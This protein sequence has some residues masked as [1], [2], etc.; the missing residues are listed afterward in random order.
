MSRRFVLVNFEFGPFQ[1]DGPGRALRLM[2]REVPLQPRVFDLLVYLVHNRARVVSKD[3]LLDALWPGVTVTEGALQRAVSTLRAALREGGM[4]EAIRS[5]PRIG[6]RF[7]QLPEIERG[8]A[9]ADREPAS[10]AAAR[11]AIAEQR[12]NDAA[13]LYAAIDAGETLE[14]ADLD[15]W[16]LAEQCR[17]K[18]VDAV[19]MLARSVAVHVRDGYSDAAA[20]SAVALCVIHFERGDVA[21]ARGW[22]ARAEDLL[23]ANP[24][25]P[26]I[27]RAMWMQSRFAAYDGDPQRALELAEATYLLGQKMDI[28]TVEAL[29]LMYRGF[30]KLSLGDTQGGPADQDHAAA[31]SLSSNIDPLTGGTL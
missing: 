26:A 17:G 2:G 15:G 20:E 5:F 11:Q 27:G 16:A 28:L 29:G 4:E 7:S 22:L 10:L 25:A 31:I 13:R 8:L 24:H 21:V 12:W 3:E 23:A 19:P 6:Y 9:A 1:L 18:P 14:G 30:Y